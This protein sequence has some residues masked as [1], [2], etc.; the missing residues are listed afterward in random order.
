MNGLEIIKITKIMK[1]KRKK[2]KGEEKVACMTKEEKTKRIELAT[3][4]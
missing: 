3:L 2:K 1:N 4:I